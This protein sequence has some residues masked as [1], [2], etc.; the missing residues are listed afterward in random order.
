VAV[1]SD[2]PEPATHLF[3]N[4]TLPAP[5][6]PT[7]GT[8]SSQKTVSGTVKT[9]APQANQPAAEKTGDP[10]SDAV[11]T[12]ETAKDTDKPP[13]QMEKAAEQVEETAKKAKKLFKSF[14]F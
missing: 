3:A 13:S 5:A 8:P 9:G 1:P 10:V 12:A 7:S 11:E 2:S 14:G 6:G 4:T